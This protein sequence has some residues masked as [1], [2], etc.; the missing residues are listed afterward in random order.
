[1][2]GLQIKLARIRRGIKQGEL[3]RSVGMIQKKLCWIE[4]GKQKATIEEIAAI[5]EALGLKNSQ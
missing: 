2:T 4:S 5:R 1:M 3:A